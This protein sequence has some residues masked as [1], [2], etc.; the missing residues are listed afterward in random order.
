MSPRQ[1]RIL[2]YSAGRS[3]IGQTVRAA[4]I[5]RY[6]SELLQSQAEIL[7]VTGVRYGDQ[8]FRS[9]RWRAAAPREIIEIVNGAA[10]REGTES[11]GALREAASGVTASLV[12][13]F[14]PDI[15][16]TTSHRGVAGEIREVADLLHKRH[17]RLVL[18][19]RDIYH[20]PEFVNDFRAMSG[21]EFDH[22]LI[23]GPRA[24]RGWAPEGLLDGPLAP[25]V[26]CAGY[27][28]PVQDPLAETSKEARQGKKANDTK[29]G[30]DTF[31]IR[32]QV[33]GGRDG[34]PLAKAVIEAVD[35]IR[36]DSARRVELYL[37]TGPLMSRSDVRALKSMADEYTHVRI[38]SGGS[39]TSSARSGPR[40]HL[41]V[42]MAGYN[43]CVEAAWTGLPSIIVPREDPDDLEQGI[44]AQLFSGW[45]PNI[46]IAPKD[47]EGIANS[48][49]SALCREVSSRYASCKARR[50]EA[51]P[52]SIFALPRRVALSVLGQR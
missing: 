15:F 34:A 19:L 29:E 51:R 41:V 49:N 44:R 45:F 13:D 25:K 21:A 11:L 52:D 16:I 32:C 22:V 23:G 48:I 14:R 18:A 7:L 38:W 6:I 9:P 4:R 5:A 17:C 42:S 33:G 36:Q 40:P 50:G 43:S 46:A 24:V 27:L 2:L 10:E 8:V 35:S 26:H 37:A 12:S 31:V 39:A 28:R 1:T 20:P 47:P 30:D 3:G